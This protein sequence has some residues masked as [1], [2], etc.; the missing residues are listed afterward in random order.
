MGGFNTKSL[1]AET[2][3]GMHYISGPVFWYGKGV[4]ELFL[5]S[6]LYQNK[7]YSVGQSTIVIILVAEDI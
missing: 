3:P 6:S 1:K 7:P 4:P 2:P 5:H